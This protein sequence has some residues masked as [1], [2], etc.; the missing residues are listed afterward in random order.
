MP[1]PVILARAP[2][3]FTLE[4][5]GGSAIWGSVSV[6]SGVGTADER[7]VEH[8]TFTDNLDNEEVV[9]SPKSRLPPGNYSCVFKVVLTKDLNGTFRYRHLV[10]G[11]P[12]FQD[13]G[14]VDDPG[15]PT[16]GGGARDEYVL[17][18]EA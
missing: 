15:K 11:T 3:T 16:N 5:G 2:V 18:I 9:V 4:R 12:V 13:D 1:P 14:V 7:R 10:D 6:W 17:S 8:I